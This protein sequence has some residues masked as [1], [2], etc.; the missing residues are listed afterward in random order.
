[1][2]V[3]VYEQQVSRV[4]PNISA[5]Q[6]LRPPE[7]AFGS[8]VA[9]AATR[10]GETGQEIAKVMMLHA[11]RMAQE[12]EDVETVQR[13]NSYKQ[14]MQNRAFNEQ[15]DKN[16]KPLGFLSRKL[17]Q[18]QGATEEFDKLYR[19]QIKKQYLYKLSD[20]QITKLEPAMDSYALSL[21]ENIIQHEAAQW[22]E[23]VKNTVEADTQQRVMDASTI[24]DSKSLG[25]AVDAAIETAKLYN[26]RF[27]EATKKI[28][29]NKIAED[30]VES[31]VI[32][33]LKTTGNLPLTQ[34]LLD[35][36]KD[37]LSGDT[38]YN[39]IRGRIAEG[40]NIMQ[41]QMEK[42][43]L[44]NRVADRFDYI[45]RIANG[46]LSWENSAE[47]IRG[48]AVKDPDLAEAMNKV[49]KSKKGYFV[50]E[51]NN[52]AFQELAKD[53]FTAK[54]TESISKFLL[55]ALKE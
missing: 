4:T 10:L 13:L 15:A 3:P 24:R 11:Q 40:Y 7:E 55:Q 38:K 44:E 6:Q 30:I 27:D 18:A 23:N 19:E 53:I 47:I 5:P 26:S 20:S 12:A 48:I 1:M 36:V 21:R 14:D 25:L 39:E 2:K 31:A 54:D 8:G 43:R 33:T 16:G 41:S 34:S 52:E 28:M 9:E 22:R 35:G 32:S 29:D 45:G 46:T 17:G 49:F 37:K 42:V 50:E 51:I